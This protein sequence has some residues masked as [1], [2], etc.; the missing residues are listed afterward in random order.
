LNHSVSFQLDQQQL[1]ESELF[2]GALNNQQHYFDQNNLTMCQTPTTAHANM[3][4]PINPY[5][6]KQT[7]P[8][9]YGVSFINRSRSGSM[10]DLRDQFCGG[11]ITPTNTN[12]DNLNQSGFNTIYGIDNG[13]SVAAAAAEFY[14]EFNAYQRNYNNNNI[15]NKNRTMSQ[16]YNTNTAARLIKA[17]KI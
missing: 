11:K 9:F 15:N 7:K 13:A 1:T 8:P 4:T 3:S 14:Q 6:S 16:Q 5:L 12:T 10:L 17:S 2:Y